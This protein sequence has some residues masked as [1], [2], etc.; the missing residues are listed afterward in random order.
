MPRPKGKIKRIREKSMVT[1]PKNP[2]LIWRLRVP[3][4]SHPGTYHIVEIYDSGDMRC[5]CVAAEMG[6][7]CRHMQDT[8]FYLKQ[9][10]AKLDKNYGLRIKNDNKDSEKGESI[11]ADRQEMSAKQDIELES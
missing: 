3:S 4:K 9:L 1:D 8:L 10:T 2:K 6:K 7:V 5:D 11:R